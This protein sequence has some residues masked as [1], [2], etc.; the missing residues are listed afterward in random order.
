MPQCING[1]QIGGQTSIF[2]PHFALGSHTYL[3]TSAKAH[4]DSETLN[5]NHSVTDEIQ[6][7][8]SHCDKVK[9]AVMP[10]PVSPAARASHM[11]ILTATSVSVEGDFPV[12]S[13]LGIVGT[14]PALPSVS[15]SPLPV[16]PPPPPIP[17]SQSAP[18]LLSLRVC[19]PYGISEAGA[20][21]PLPLSLSSSSS[22]PPLHAPISAPTSPLSSLKGP[23]GILPC[24]LR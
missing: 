8:W 9:N 22:R 12:E 7:H 20:R 4:S 13:C 24:S 1:G 19:H 5:Y 16:S 3:T 11:N 18:H 6:V 17:P 10:C 21:H 23:G 2:H 14:R 15:S